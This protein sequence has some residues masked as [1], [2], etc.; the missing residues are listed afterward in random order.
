MSFFNIVHLGGLLSRLDNATM[1][2]SIEGRVPFTDHQLLEA[3]AMLPENL[4]MKWRDERSEA[5]AQLLNSDQ[6]S[7]NLDVPKYVLKE[8]G[9]KYL[10]A[11]IVYRKKIGFPVP[12]L[13]WMN[14]GHFDILLD[15]L[16]SSDNGLKNY[17]KVDQLIQKTRASGLDVR[18][19]HALWS[20]INL[21]TWLDAKKLSL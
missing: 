5:Q 4:L 14:S 3:C 17:F 2:S 13:Q 8:V 1:A 12:L 10:P 18:T 7:E 15:E 11:N 6:I 19:S 16:A 9:L 20:L 21:N